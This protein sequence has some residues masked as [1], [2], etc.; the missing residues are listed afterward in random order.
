MIFFLAL[1]IPTSTLNFSSLWTPPPYLTN[2]YNAAILAMYSLV[3]HCPHSSYGQVQFVDHAQSATFSHCSG[4]FQ[5][6]LT[7]CILPH[8]YNTNLA[9]SHTLELS[10]CQFMPITNSFSLNGFQMSLGGLFNFRCFS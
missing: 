5:I 10:C 2:V 1:L 9:L 3:L 8:I 4:L 7:V 6:C